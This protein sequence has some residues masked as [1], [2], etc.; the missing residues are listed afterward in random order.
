MAA[1]TESDQFLV[2][3]IILATLPLES[4]LAR[5]TEQAQELQFQLE[6][7]EGAKGNDTLNASNFSIVVDGST[8]RFGGWVRL[9][10]FRP[11]GTG[12]TSASF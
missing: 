4:S 6:D 3:L 12:L 8:S 2:A 11:S 9:I 7:H 10:E 1:I 5:R